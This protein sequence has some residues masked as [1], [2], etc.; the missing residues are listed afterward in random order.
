MVGTKKTRRGD[1]EERLEEEANAALKYIN[2]GGCVAGWRRVG[3][4]ERKG[5]VISGVEDTLRVLA[6]CRRVQRAGCRGLRRVGA[7]WLQWLAR[8]RANRTIGRFLLPRGLC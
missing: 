3:L 4:V 8:L 2:I 7:G 6:V 5:K 1:E